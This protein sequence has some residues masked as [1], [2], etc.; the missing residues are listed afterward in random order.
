MHIFK[1]YLTMGHLNNVNNK[2]D[3]D[4]IEDAFHSEDFI[5]CESENYEDFLAKNS[6]NKMMGG[7]M[8]GGNMMGK[9]I[10]NSTMAGSNNL[11]KQC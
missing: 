3:F 9:N 4:N 11:T 1:P 10:S 7:N 2:R 8:M 5:M 6:T